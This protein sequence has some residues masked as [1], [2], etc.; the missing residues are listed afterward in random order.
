MKLGGRIDGTH[1]RAV[2]KKE[3][4]GR[5]DRSG[6][7]EVCIKLKLCHFHLDI[8]VPAISVYAQTLEKK[9]EIKLLLFNLFIAMVNKYKKIVS[10][11]IAKE[12]L[13]L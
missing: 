12:N 2:R 5:F 8:Y 13:Q 6:V 1:K 9:S 11:I 10:K 4:G 3:F 7:R